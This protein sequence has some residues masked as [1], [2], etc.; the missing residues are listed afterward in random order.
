[1]LF[2][3]SSNKHIG[4]VGETVDKET[5][6]LGLARPIISCMTL[7]FISCPISLSM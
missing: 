3:H 4:L 7:D 1:M 2:L 5:Q 6:L